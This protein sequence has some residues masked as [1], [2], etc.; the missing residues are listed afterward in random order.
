[1]KDMGHNG[2]VEC[3]RYF[4]VFYASCMRELFMLHIK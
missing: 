4:K 3:V 2:H 1:M